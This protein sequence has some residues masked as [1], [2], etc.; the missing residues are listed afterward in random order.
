[1]IPGGNVGIDVIKYGLTQN[2]T[3]DFTVNTDFAQVEA[4]E[5]QVNLTR[6]SLFFPEKREFFL[7]NQGTFAFGTGGGL[8]TGRRLAGCADSFLQ[9]ADSGCTGDA[10]FRFAVAAGS[11]VEPG[12]FTL[13]LLN[14]HTGDEPTAA[15]LAPDSPS[16]GSNATAQAQQHR[17]DLHATGRNPRV[18]SDGTN[19]AYGAD[20][21][22][23]FLRQPFDQRLLGPDPNDRRTPGRLELQRPASLQRAIGTARRQSTSSSTSCSRPRVGFVRRRDMRKS[24]G[25]LRFSPRPASIEAIRKFQLGRHIQL[26]HGRLRISSRLA[27]GRA[28]SASS[29]RTAIAFSCRIRATTTSSSSRF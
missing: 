27:T 1:M 8:R 9:P 7:E 6:F 12:A 14:I 23:A 15:R 17:R 2:L 21:T 25:S 16:P 26:H 24:A 28:G 29:S 19:Q 11:P 10:R 18:A 4:D 3:A 20:A 13:G 5:Q 22:F